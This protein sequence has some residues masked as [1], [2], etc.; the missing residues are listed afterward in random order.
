MVLKNGSL[1]I[2]TT[3]GKSA[4]LGTIGMSSGKWYWET[5]INGSSD[6]TMVGIGKQGI[7]LSDAPGQGDALGWGYYAD[8]GVKRNGGTSTSYGAGFD[9]GGDVIGCA[10]DADNGT[11]TFYKN[12]SS[13]GVAFTG[14]TD[15]PYFPATGDGSGVNN[16]NSSVNFGQRAWAYSAPS[17]HKALCTTNLPASTVADGSDYQDTVLYTG[18]GASSRTISGLSFSPDFLWIKVRDNTGGDFSPRIMDANR[19]AGVS[20]RSNGNDAERDSSATTGGGVETFT[21]DGFTIQSGGGSN[22]NANNNN[23][24]YVA[25]AW[26]SGSSTASNNNGSITSNVR[27]SAASGFSVVRWTGNGSSSASVGHGLSAAPDLVIIKCR[28]SAT[29]WHTYA[30]A[31]DANGRYQ[32]YLNKTNAKT[33]FGSNFFSASSSVINLNSSSLGINGNGSA[34]VGYCFAPVAGYS[35]FGTYIGNGSSN[36]PFI[37]TGFRVKWLMVKGVDFA[38]NWNIFDVAR[39]GYNETDLVLRANLSNAEFD[40]SAQGS[41]ALGVDFL[42]NGFKLV[43]PGTDFNNNTNTHL[44][45]AFAENP[46]QANGGLAR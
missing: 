3:S 33:D 27:A 9:G 39:P 26:D 19:G 42:S 2:A 16:A 7:D 6:R 10:F 20:L 12:G 24:P 36:G 23:S 41:F 37:Y 46:F 18:N 35:A 45:M 38:G 43:Q 30:R 14:L 21:S 4:V 5:T 34:Y 13:Q 22:I 11:L 15:G 17:N 1:D 8:G 25:W 29:D 28:G 44:Y 32:V 40:G 31:V